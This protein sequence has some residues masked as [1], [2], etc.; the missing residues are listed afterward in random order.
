MKKT[1]DLVSRGAGE[2]LL[3]TDGEQSRLCYYHRNF[4]RSERVCNS[5]KI[6]GRGNSL[7]DTSGLGGAVT[8]LLVTLYFHTAHASDGITPAACKYKF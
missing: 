6:G 5:F 1:E 7:G 8:W 2:H 4:Q 3:W